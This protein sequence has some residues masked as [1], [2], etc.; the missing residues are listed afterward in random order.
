[1]LGG[2]LRRYRPPLPRS[3]PMVLSLLPPL[4]SLPLPM[5]FPLKHELLWMLIALPPLLPARLVQG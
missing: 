5:P 1:M 2:S 3:P 4:A